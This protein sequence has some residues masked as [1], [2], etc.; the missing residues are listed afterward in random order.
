[1]IPEINI[2]LQ[3]DVMKIFVV[4][5]FLFFSLSGCSLVNPGYISSKPNTETLTPNKSTRSDVVSILGDP[6][7]SHMNFVDHVS[8]IYYYNMP[9]AFVDIGLMIKGDYSS[10]CRDC[11][12][13]VATF[14]KEKDINSKDLLLTGL[15]VSDKEIDSRMYTACKLLGEQK[16][17]EA[18]PIIL[19]GAEGHSSEGQ[20]YLGLMYINGDG[21]EKDYKK[22]FYWFARAAGANYPPALYDLGAMYRNGEGVPVNIPAAMHLYTKSAN[23]GNQQAII[24]LI[25]MYKIIEDQKQVDFWT[26][27]LN[28]SLTTK[29]SKSDVEPK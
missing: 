24:E 27:K 7:I 15:S 14:K 18:Y 25:K 11:G 16:F 29:Q 2:N 8:Y 21:V 3:G 1:M 23:F 26:K 22:A 20:H 12:K 4:L 6:A 17:S 28:Q 5:S 19:K 10:G 13:I 9:N